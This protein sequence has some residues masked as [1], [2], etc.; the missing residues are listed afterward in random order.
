MRLTHAELPQA[1]WVELISTATYVLNR[2]EPS[3]VEG[4]SPHE[5][6]YNKKPKITH[7]RVKLLVLRMFMFQI[8]DGRRW[9]RKLR[10]VF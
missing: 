1:L 10:T 5:L 6:W 7:L 9:M 8:S 4:K 3:S 2:T